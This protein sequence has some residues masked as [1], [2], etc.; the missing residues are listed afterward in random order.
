MA[1]ARRLLS[2]LLDTDMPQAPEGT[3]A[4]LIV[5]PSYTQCS[6]CNGHA[7]SR[8]QTHET[9]AGFGKAGRKGCGAKFTAI[10]TGYPNITDAILHSVRPDLPIKA[11]KEEQ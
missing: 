11:L 6:H 7:F 9:L 10:T 5:S 1:R 2:E 3:E 4:M 8:E